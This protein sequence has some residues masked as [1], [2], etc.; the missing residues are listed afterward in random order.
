MS[1]VGRGTHQRRLLGVVRALLEG[2]QLD[3]RELGR[4]LQARLAAAD[5]YLRDIKS[6]LPIAVTREER[7]RRYALVPSGVNRKPTLAQA[8]AA[9]FGAGLAGVVEGVRYS[10]D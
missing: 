9:S 1:D 8:I 6:T 10:T 2:E 5:R 3:R 7:T 4:R